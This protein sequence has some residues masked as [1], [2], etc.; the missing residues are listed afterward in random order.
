M[1]V[2]IVIVIVVVIVVMVAV[3]VRV[4]PILVSGRHTLKSEDLN[5]RKDTPFDSLLYATSNHASEVEVC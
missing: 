3:V 5:L 2:A 4:E 1:V